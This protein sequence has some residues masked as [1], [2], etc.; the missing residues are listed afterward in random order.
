MNGSLAITGAR[1]DRNGNDDIS[2]GGTGTSQMSKVQRY[3]LDNGLEGH[4]SATSTNQQNV[5]GLLGDPGSKKHPG[6]GE[7]N[8]NQNTATNAGTAA[9]VAAMAA[10]GM[11][12]NTNGPS[13]TS[14]SRGSNS[15]HEK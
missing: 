15:S 9:V 14:I 6:T 1:F 10:N 5:A 13:G 3:S 2:V 11:K 4:F 12:G 7:G 8:S